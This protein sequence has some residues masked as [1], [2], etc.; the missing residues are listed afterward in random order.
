M[1]RM[2]LSEEE[3]KLIKEVRRKTEI[4]RTHNAALDLAIDILPDAL[5][6]SGYDNLA[7]MEATEAFKKQLL[8]HRRSL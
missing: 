4:D 8:S 1:P 7:Q 3:V 5:A 2:E 6:A